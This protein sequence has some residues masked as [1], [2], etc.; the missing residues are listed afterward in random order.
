MAGAKEDLRN[1]HRRHG[2]APGCK[3]AAQSRGCRR[4][5]QGR[6]IAGGDGNAGWRRTLMLETVDLTR[7]L[8]RDAYVRE[9]TR[10]QIQLRD[11]GYQIYLRKRPVVIAFE[12]GTREVRAAPSSGSPRNWTPAATWYTPSPRRGRSEERR[13]GKEGRSR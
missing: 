1:H 10:R 4:G 8:D 5:G 6:G 2:K 7:R 9:I 11:L 12:G 3:R 13:V